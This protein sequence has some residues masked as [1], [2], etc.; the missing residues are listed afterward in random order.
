[1]AELFTGDAVA[2]SVERLVSIGEVF[3]G[4]CTALHLLAGYAG[5]GSGQEQCK[6]YQ[7]S[8][9]SVL[10]IEVSTIPSLTKIVKIIS[11]IFKEDVPAFLALR[12]AFLIFE[13]I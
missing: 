2:V 13:D 12:M 9:H 7:V 1:M 4:L 11:P 5:V 10:D 6:N 8:H 3:A